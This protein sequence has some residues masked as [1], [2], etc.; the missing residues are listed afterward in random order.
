[1]TKARNATNLL[2]AQLAVSSTTHRGLE[3][4]RTQ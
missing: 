4:R 1:M 3:Q 2:I